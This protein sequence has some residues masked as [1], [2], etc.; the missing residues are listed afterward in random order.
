MV[1]R[2][3]KEVLKIEAQGILSLVDRLG[4]DFEKA[5]ETIM[6]AKGRVILAGMGKSGLIAL[7]HKF[8]LDDIKEGDYVIKYGQKIGIAT[9]NI[10]QGEWIHTHNIISSYL[11]EVLNL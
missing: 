10:L 9:S 5:I 7:G 3:A 2:Q 6:K 4:P 1:I 8:A 11:K